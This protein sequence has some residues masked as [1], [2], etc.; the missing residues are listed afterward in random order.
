MKTEIETM[1][2]DLKTLERARGIIGDGNC[3][4]E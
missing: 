1:K 4:G 2:E 3:D